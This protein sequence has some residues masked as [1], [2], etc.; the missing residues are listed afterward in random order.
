M[1]FP[2]VGFS[3]SGVTMTQTIGTVGA[4]CSTPPPL[5]SSCTTVPAEYTQV[6]QYCQNLCARVCAVTVCP[7]SKAFLQQSPVDSC[8]EDCACQT[9]GL[10]LNGVCVGGEWDQGPYSV[11]QLRDTR[12]SR[13]SAFLREI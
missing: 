12:R 1:A 10:S 6:N 5:P 3:T 7:S 8:Y 4:A 9:Q 2:S 13:G 11:T